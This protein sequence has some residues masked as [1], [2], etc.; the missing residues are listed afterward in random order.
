MHGDNDHRKI[1]S[2]TTTVMEERSKSRSKQ[3]FL[4][5][6]QAGTGAR[7]PRSLLMYASV[8][9]AHC[10]KCV[11]LAYVIVGRLRPE[12][13]IGVTPESNAM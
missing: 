11:T 10:A 1:S 6:W 5:S 7:T 2:L 8:R 9:G 13:A 12:S 3:A 4:D